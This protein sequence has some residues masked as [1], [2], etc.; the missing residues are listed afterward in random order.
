MKLGSV[1]LVNKMSIV[2]FSIVIFSVFETAY[3]CTYDQDC[4]PD[5]DYCSAGFCYNYVN[6]APYYGIGGGFFALF[7]ICLLIWLIIRRQRI[8]RQQ[9]NIFNI[10]MARAIRGQSNYLNTVSQQVVVQPSTV[11]PVHQEQ[12]T[13]YPV[14]GYVRMS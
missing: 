2:M 10:H 9:R 12:S 11:V 7:L 5:F 8:N 4:Y 3:G 13:T 6:Y 1:Q 14:N